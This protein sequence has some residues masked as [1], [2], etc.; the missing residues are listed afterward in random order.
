M[1]ATAHRVESPRG[2]TGIN[3]F[4]HTHGAAFS[5]PAD[6]VQ[7]P[8]HNPGVLWW[9]NGPE[10]PPGGNRVRSYLDLLAPDDTPAAEVE[11]ALT[12]LWLELVADEAGPPAAQGAL[13][14]PVD[15]RHGAV[16]LRF[17]VDLAMLPGRS[18]E[19]AELRRAV[20]AA[21]ARWFAAAPA[22][23]RV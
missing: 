13:P 5:W 20:D 15:Y 19:M 12:S 10:V 18:L 14:N 6:P 9:D 4:L 17:G 21:T 16:V 11:A 7:L 8:E 2:L 1:Y 23:G 22:P 3:T